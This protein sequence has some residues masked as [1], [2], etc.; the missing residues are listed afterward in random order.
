MPASVRAATPSGLRSLA[1]ITAIHVAVEELN[2]A[3]QKTGLRKEQV[4]AV[5]ET[6]LTEH[7]IK[8]T[9]PGGGAPILYV[10]VSSVVGG[11]QAQ[12]PISFYL[13]VQVK[14]FV[15][16]PPTQNETAAQDSKSAA[17]LLVT[18]WEDG[19]MV[20]TNRAELGFYVRQVL[21]NVLGEFL[22]DYQDAKKGKA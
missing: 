6:Y 17:P 4:Q 14:Q 13:T 8:L 22:Q 1:G 19:T 18:T 15:H 20:M 7:E 3:T 16:F 5:V 12:A 9:G 11:E 21:L 10:R 2:Y